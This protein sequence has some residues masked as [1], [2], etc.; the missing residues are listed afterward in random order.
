MNK[1]SIICIGIAVILAGCKKDAVIPEKDFTFDF[2]AGAE[3]WIAGFADYPAGEETFY[4]LASDHDTIPSVAVADHKGLEIQGNNHSDDLFMYFKKQVEGLE[5][6]TEYEVTFSLEMASQYPE[7][8]FGVGGSPGSSV[9]IKAGA[10]R[11]EP[12][13]AQGQNDM[14]MTMNIDKGNQAQEGDD[15]INLGTV[16][17]T[18]DDF[19]YKIIERDNDEKPFSVTS[20]SEG[21]VWLIVGTDSGFEGLSV[22]YYDKI[23]ARFVP[24]E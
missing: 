16:G 10:V 21:K 24:K 19:V 9:Y 20:D 6:G 5:P 1:L 13:A 15:M 3:G 7:N 14:Q 8:S 22:L 11:V 18:G 17:I 23:A 12:V 4:E 2:E